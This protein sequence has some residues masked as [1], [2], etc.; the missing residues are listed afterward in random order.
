MRST[1]SNAEGKVTASLE[2]AVKDLTNAKIS[3]EKAGKARDRHQRGEKR[4]RVCANFEHNRAA[5]KE[6]KTAKKR[7]DADLAAD[8]SDLDPLEPDLR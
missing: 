2:M 7:A 6:A 5:A 8:D 1:A 4:R 3:L